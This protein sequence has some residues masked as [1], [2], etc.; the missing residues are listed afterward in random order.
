MRQKERPKTSFVRTNPRD[1]PEGDLDELLVGPID[2]D[3]PSEGFSI[4][5]SML[6]GQ[7]V[8]RISAFADAWSGMLSCAHLLRALPIVPES[9][10]AYG[11]PSVEQVIAALKAAG[12][13]DDTRPSPYPPAGTRP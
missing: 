5:W 1:L 9:S 7:R 4:V 11:H 2:D 13:E 3:G 6:D 12:C 10:G 8:A